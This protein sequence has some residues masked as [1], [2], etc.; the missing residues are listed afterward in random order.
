MGANMEARAFNTVEVEDE[1]N[2][3]ARLALL[4]AE[5]KEI[6]KIVSTHETVFE[7]IDEVQKIVTKIW[8]AVKFGAP[9]VIGA[10]V[11]AGYID[12][13]F[14]RLLGAIFQ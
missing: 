1:T 12:G 2:I 8:K 11:T 5:V 9:T 4:E 7:S 10:A 14:G 13:T 6:R 3:L